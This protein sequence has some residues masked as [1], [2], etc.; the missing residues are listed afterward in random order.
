MPEIHVRNARD[1]YV[2]KSND[3]IRTK[4]QHM[5]LQQMR[6]LK[7]CTY[8]R[9]S[10]RSVSDVAA[11]VGYASLSC[12]NQHFQRVMGCTPSVWRRSGA[13]VRPSLV[14]R[15]G[16]LEAEEPEDAAVNPSGKEQH[17]VP[18]EI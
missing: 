17:H 7:S 4:Q 13:P 18:Q 12:F 2:V 1:Q 14:Q 10:K 9:T 15:S 5:S 11:Q 16:W 3:L 6:I 8:L